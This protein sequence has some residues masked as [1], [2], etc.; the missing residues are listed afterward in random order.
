MKH[1]CRKVGKSLKNDIEIGGKCERGNL[2]EIV[3]K[4]AGR[5]SL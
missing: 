5:A 2:F 3:I 1:A 4:N